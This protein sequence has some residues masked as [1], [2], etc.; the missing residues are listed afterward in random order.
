MDLK[1]AHQ[2]VELFKRITKIWRCGLVWGGVLP[3]VGYEV[4][5]AQAQ[6]RVCLC[7]G[8]R[9]YLSATWAPRLPAAMFS[10]MIIM[11]EASETIK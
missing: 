9:M 6:P 3:G 10:A 2:R 7:Y 5:K 8:I 4:L 1:L 11:E